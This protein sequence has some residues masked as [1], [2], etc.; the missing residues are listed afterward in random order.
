MNFAFV[1]TEFKCANYKKQAVESNSDN[2]LSVFQTF[3][4]LKGNMLENFG[5]PK[6]TLGFFAH[7]RAANSYFVV[8]GQ[9][10]N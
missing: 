1:K 8:S 5:F 10:I 2:M 9:I 6:H 4:V 7:S 3:G